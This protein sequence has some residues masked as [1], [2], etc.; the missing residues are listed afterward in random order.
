MR[1][2]G[3][4]A[5]EY[6]ATLTVDGE[7]VATETG[8]I[9]AESQRVVPLSHTFDEPGEYTVGVGDETVPVRVEPAAEPAVT[10]LT[11]SPRTVQQGERAEVTLTVGNSAAVPANGTVAVTR[12][13]EPATQRVVT[14][15]PGNTTRLAV[16]I[17]FPEAGEIQVGAGSADP[18]TVTVEGGLVGVAGPG[19]T[20]VAALVAVALGLLVGRRLE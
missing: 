9:G 20:P 6:N 2:T 12:N 10:N 13:G 1:N 11:V 8:T 15:G 7:A 17:P 14:L 19:F 3:G 18:V 4:E 5:G 16:A